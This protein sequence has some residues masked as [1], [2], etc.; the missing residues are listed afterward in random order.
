MTPNSREVDRDEPLGCRPAYARLTQPDRC[1]FTL[2]TTGLADTSILAG[3]SSRLGLVECVLGGEH[4][5]AE[6]EVGKGDAVRGLRVERSTVRRGRALEGPQADDS[7]P[8]SSG[9]PSRSQWL[10]SPRRDD[11]PSGRRGKG[12][13]Q[14]VRDSCE[15]EM[16]ADGA[17]AGLPRQLVWLNRADSASHS[18][19]RRIPHRLHTRGVAGSIPA[20][21]IGKRPGN[22]AFLDRQSPHD[23]RQYRL[24]QSVCRASLNSADGVGR[25]VRHTVARAPERVTISACCP[26]WQG[27]MSERDPASARPQGSVGSCR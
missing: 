6:L 27:E 2:H 14:S 13:R 11:R 16:A 19:R 21:P 22:S 17:R 8:R 12:E 20:A 4:S 18:Y 9:A 5:P 25:C 24:L 7:G 26:E 3:R 10:A 1:E 23:P 15:I